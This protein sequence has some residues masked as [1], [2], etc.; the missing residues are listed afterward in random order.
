MRITLASPNVDI[1]E[2]IRAYAEYRLFSSVARHEL[3]VRTIDVV[4]RRAPA[5]QRF[6][7]VLC[8]HVGPSGQVKTQ[9]RRPNVTAAIDRAADRLAWLVDRRMQQ[10]ISS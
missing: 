7:C 1:P 9:A 10:L 5:T 6:V 2:H 8:A 4:I 3:H